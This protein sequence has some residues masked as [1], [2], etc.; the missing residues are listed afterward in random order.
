MI[1]IEEILFQ[2][3]FQRNRIGAEQ[4]ETVIIDGDGKG[5]GA[6]AAQPVSQQNGHA[7]VYHASFKREHKKMMAFI[8]MVQFDE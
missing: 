4:F 7:F 6:D 8:G 1:G 3:F 2:S 5:H